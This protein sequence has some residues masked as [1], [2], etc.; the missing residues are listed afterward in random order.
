MRQIVAWQFVAAFVNES[1]IADREANSGFIDCT[2]A[3]WIRPAYWPFIALLTRLKYRSP[4]V[5]HSSRYLQANCLP[6]RVFAG[7]Y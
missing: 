1:R 4:I 6:S 5:S 2:R 7:A 3:A